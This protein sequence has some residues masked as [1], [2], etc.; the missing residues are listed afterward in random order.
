MVKQYDRHSHL[1]Y[2]HRAHSCQFGFPKA[3]SPKTIIC[4]EPNDDENW[5]TILKSACDVLTKVH[6]LIDAATEN[7]TLDSILDKA[8]ISTD[9]YINALKVS[10]QG[11]SVI[12]KHDPSDVN[13][14]GCNHEILCLWEANI[15]FQFVL[16][17][18]STVMYIC[19]YMMKREKAMGEVLKS[20][21]HEC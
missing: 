14:N 17:E 9:A 13:I 5:D 10:H 15:D 7:Q 12:L 2:C 19:S 16:D 6:E 8:H 4:R 3:P 11:C 21:A 20:V 1:A 18:Y